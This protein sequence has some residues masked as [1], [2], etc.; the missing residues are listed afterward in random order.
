MFVYSIFKFNE[1][2]FYMQIKLIINY[3]INNTQR[4]KIKLIIRNF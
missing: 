2:T 4:T 1:N 3:F